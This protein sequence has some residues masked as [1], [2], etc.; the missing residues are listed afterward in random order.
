[1]M[2]G[3]T[4]LFLLHM[5]EHW[6]WY[7]LGEEKWISNYFIHFKLLFPISHTEKYFKFLNLCYEYVWEFLWA[8]FFKVRSGENES[9]Y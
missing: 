4:I 9:D 6:T 3:Q 5:L 2:I 1:M 7:E 8:F